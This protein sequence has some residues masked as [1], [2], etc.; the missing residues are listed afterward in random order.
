MFEPEA[1]GHSSVVEQILELQY[2]QNMCMYGTAH[3]CLRLR[4]YNSQHQITSAQG[5]SVVAAGSRTNWSLKFNT[6]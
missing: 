3:T 4:Y 1:G 5:Q 6:L 2:T